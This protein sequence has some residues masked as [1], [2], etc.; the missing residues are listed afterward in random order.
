MQVTKEGDYALRAV[1]YLASADGRTC[2]ANEVS[3]KQCVPQK[4]LARIMPKLVKQKIISS[5]P[6]SKGGYRLARSAADIS[7]LEVLEAIEGE[8]NI[9]ACLQE[10]FVDCDHESLCSMKQ[11]WSDAQEQLKNYFSSV[12]FDQLT[13]PPCASQKISACS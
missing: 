4:F 2:S 10:D 5:L 13:E 7:F 11:V 3:E 9:N 1:I 12:T 6:G 8:M